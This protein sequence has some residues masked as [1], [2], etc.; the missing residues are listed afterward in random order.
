LGHLGTQLA[1]SFKDARLY[2]TIKT[3]HVANLRA[4]IAALNARDCYAVGHAA[5]LAVTVLLLGRELD[6]PEEHLPQIIEASFLHDVGRTGVADS[7]L[8]KLGSLSDA[9]TSELRNHPVAGAKIVRSLF[10]QA[11]HPAPLAC[12]S[13]LVCRARTAPGL[14][15]E[16]VKSPSPISAESPPAC[17]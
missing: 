13:A 8:F 7:V 4:L 2:E 17:A 15:R 14:R 6:W 16:S 1:L 9:E 12:F 3:M 10:R 11:D 5:R